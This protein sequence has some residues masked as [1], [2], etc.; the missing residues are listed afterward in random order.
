MKLVGK[1]LTLA[2]VATSLSG[3]LG[4]EDL[5][6]TG[7]LAPPT[8]TP[9]T[10]TPPTTTV[11]TNANSIATS[12]GVALGATISATCADATCATAPSA[13]NIKTSKK[14]VSDVSVKGTGNT[15]IGTLALSG[16]NNFA[17]LANLAFDREQLDAN[18]A[19]QTA[20]F[21]S[22]PVG[23][24]NDFT[25]LT[26]A[27]KNASDPF[28]F[29]EQSKSTTSLQADGSTVGTFT[30][31][32][33]VQG[34]KTPVANLKK[35][36]TFKGTGNVIASAPTNAQLGMN[37]QGDLTLVADVTNAKISGQIANLQ[38]VTPVPLANG[39]GSTL[40]LNEGTI[41][42]ADFG[43]GSLTL[44]NSSGATIIDLPNTST[45]AGSFFGDDMGYAAGVFNGSGNVGGEDFFLLG[46]FSG[47]A[48]P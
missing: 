8:T 12:T 45:Y 37:A 7:G 16:D 15:R 21:G 28:F 26:Y 38:S 43:G 31:I 14:M 24:T 34:S 11:T 6:N 27:K 25:S 1:V 32:F 3:C 33:G 5:L 29:F 20:R 35:T 10:I 30:K 17:G 23:A 48:Q 9:P 18:G 40:Y 22:P 42:G 2:L 4:L 41:S 39:Q 47:T 13:V 36:A 44:K 46:A 19:V